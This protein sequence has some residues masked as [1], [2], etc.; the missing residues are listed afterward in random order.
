MTAIERLRIACDAVLGDIASQH[1]HRAYK[2]N[3]EAFLAWCRDSH[4]RTIDKRAVETYLNDLATKGAS[5]ASVNQSLATIRKL[6]DVDEQFAI[7]KTIKVRKGQTNKKVNSESRRTLTKGQFQKLLNAPDLDNIKGLRDRAL[8]AVLAG[9]GLKREEIAHLTFEQI[10][11]MQGQPVITL[12][13]RTV[14]IPGWAKRALDAYKRKAGLKQGKVFLKTAKSGDLKTEPLTEQFI[15]KM[16]IAYGVSALGVE[17]TPADLRRSFAA[18][19]YERG[20]PIDQIQT[21]L[22]HD[23]IQNTRLLLGVTNQPRAQVSPG[24][25]FGIKI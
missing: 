4:A 9:C 14:P 20:T 17:T 3:L 7:F 23:S 21:L 22:G 18:L 10:G 8:L 24:D 11:R 1:T 19:A 15:T 6:A 16:V 2:R 13:D 5:P 25:R 12:H